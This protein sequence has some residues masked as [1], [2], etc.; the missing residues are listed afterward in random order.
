MGRLL[1]EIEL[2][3]ICRVFVESS[4]KKKEKKIKELDF[5]ACLFNLKIL[6]DWV[7]GGS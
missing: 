5:V 1:G 6:F 4:K 3:F 2:L 7:V